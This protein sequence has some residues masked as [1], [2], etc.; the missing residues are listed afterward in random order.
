MD[1]NN[2]ENKGL[3]EEVIDTEPIVKDEDIAKELFE[4]DIVSELHNSYLEYAMSVIVSRALPDVRDGLKPVQRRILVAMNDLNLMPTS[5]HRKSAK[6]AGDTSGNY[7]PHGEAVIYPTMVRMAQDFNSRYPLID[8]QGNMGS[9]DGDPPAAMRYTEMRMSKFA[10]EMLQDLDKDTVDWLPNYDQT[11][12]EPMVLPAKFPNLLANGSSGI[13]VGMA[14][15]IPPHNLRELCDGITY[16]IDNPDCGTD[17]LMMY[18]KGPDFPT[19]GIIQGTNGIRQAYETGRGS[20]IM[21][22]QCSIDELDNGKPVIIITELPYQVNKSA[23]ISKIALL[24]K[25]KIIDGITDIADYSDRTGMRIQ[26]ELRK[27]TRPGFIVS[28]LM[29]HTELKKTFGVIMLSL[30]GDQPKILSLK[31][32]ISYYVDHRREI[33]IRRTKYNLRLALR[34][35]HII[36]GLVIANDNIDEVIS[37]IRNAPSAAAARNTLMERFALTWQ[38]ATAILDMQ[39]RSLAGLERSKLEAEFVDYLKRI[40]QMEDLL[41]TPAKIDGVIKDELAYIKQKF[42]DERRTRI[43]P[44]EQKDASKEDHILL[45]QLVVSITREGYF[46][47]VSAD[48]YKT[49]SRQAQGK[50]AGKVKIEDSIAYM[51]VCESHDN[52][53]MFTDKGK[54]YREKISGMGTNSSR[55]AKGKPF[56][57]MVEGLEAGEKVNAVLTCSDKEL[58]DTS[59]FLIFG[60]EKGEIK[61]VSLNK[62]QHIKK[63]GI[64]VFEMNEDDILRFVKISDGGDDIIM[65]SNFGQSIRFNETDVRSSG[66]V[67]GGVRGMRLADGDRVVSMCLAKAD[68]KG[69][70]LCVTEYG[71]G[72]QTDLSEYR[73]QKRGGSG[74]KAMK[75]T[76][77]TGLVIGAAVIYEDYEFFVVNNIGKAKRLKAKTIRETGRNTQGVKII[78]LKDEDE[79]KR[80]T[81]I[82]MDAFKKIDFSDEPEDISSDTDDEEDFTLE[83]EE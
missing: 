74:T 59:K 26:I 55:E 52:M 35:T 22:A 12:K 25:N 76:D 7:H 10:V 68:E 5:A 17:D 46:K 44:K 13:A 27:D 53:L 51:F 19:A 2:N 30:V 75:C 47:K 61:R 62:F 82:S 34:R 69:N 45:E 3:D 37:I 78:T 58:R 23:L 40:A 49:Q 77:K 56:V 43:D 1:D 32:M 72:K 38:Q 20:V 80:E 36:E 65:V 6:I 16:F 63:N 60:T 24:A 57:S 4:K 41:S 15:N 18:I 81:L 8:G 50:K 66:R 70:I 39:L 67:S 42:G 14:T 73:V 29:R 21:K 9:I 48:E 83:N 28:E 54:V 64:K 79:E 11:R 31:E 33:V 71:L